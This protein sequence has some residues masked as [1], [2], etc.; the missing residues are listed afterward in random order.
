METFQVTQLHFKSVHLCCK[1]PLLSFPFFS[2]GLKIS[3]NE[4]APCESCHDFTV[5]LTQPS[6]I[7]PLSLKFPFPILAKYV[8]AT[9]H[10]KSRFVVEEISAGTLA[11]RV[12]QQKV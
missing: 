12:S 9:L 10:P 8:K 7:K 3:T 11:V 1:N 4:Q 6:K 5:S 2:T